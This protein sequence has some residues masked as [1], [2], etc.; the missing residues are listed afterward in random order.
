MEI[1]NTLRLFVVVVIV[2]VVMD[3]YNCFIDG[4]ASELPLSTKYLTSYWIGFSAF[5]D[6][7]LIVGVQW[8]ILAL[9]DRRSPSQ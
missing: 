1:D 7:P 6:S 5:W 9:L 8:R 3:E 2:V 4:R